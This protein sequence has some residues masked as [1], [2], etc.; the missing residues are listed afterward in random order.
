MALRRFAGRRQ[1]ALC[2][3]DW[4]AGARTTHPD[5]GVS[6]ARARA[7]PQG[8]GLRNDAATGGLHGI[9]GK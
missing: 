5:A 8:A 1:A 7:E 2:P 4:F 9:G 3:D 6:A